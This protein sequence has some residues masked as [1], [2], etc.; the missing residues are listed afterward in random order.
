MGIQK[1]RTI[2]EM[3]FNLG[4]DEYK[5]TIPVVRASNTAARPADGTINKQQVL[6]AA[7]VLNELFD[8]RGIPKVQ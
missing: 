7:D 6:E 8:R 2:Q 4:L 3:K 1:S 5:R